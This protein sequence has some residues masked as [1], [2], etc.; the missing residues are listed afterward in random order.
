MA[1]LGFYTHIRQFIN[2]GK[3][4]L[5]LTSRA[6]INH[7]LTLIK[8]I[9]VD[10]SSLDLAE[11]GF[12][13][14]LLIDQIIG[15]AKKVSANAL[16][17]NPW[18]DGS[19]NYLSG[20]ADQSDLGEQKFLEH[21]IDRSHEQQILIFAWLVVGKDDF[22]SLDHPEW[23]AKTIAGQ[24]YYHNDEPGVDL[25][26]ASLANQDYLNYHLSV[27][28]EV[29]QLAIDGWV[30]SEPIIGWGD[31][32]D[33]NYIDFSEAV[34]N[35]FQEKTGFNPIELFQPDSPSFWEQQT[36]L[37]QKWV[38]FR[39]AV[40][41]NHIASTINTIRQSANKTIIITLFTEPDQ[42]GRLKSLTEIKDWLGTDLEALADLKPDF[43]ELQAL[44][45]DFEFPQPPEWTKGMISQFQSQ[46]GNRSIPILVSVQGYDPGGGRL[47]A[48][49]FAKAMQNAL[50]S[51]IV[52]VSFYAYHTMDE[53][54]WRV[55][56]KLWSQY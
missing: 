38:D 30:I 22:P 1:W 24:P 34:I 4:R 44:F 42:N 45:A 54:K 50:A 55:L 53:D 37:Y 2:F 56:E 13:Q 7:P 5:P 21:L 39:A 47:T 9:R 49:D 29:N 18:S 20:I 19:A 10:L 27:V 14:N 17:V 28:K 43:F 26:V 23:F 41:T 33:T 25:P 16:F 15:R 3:H 46:L 35:L 51:P 52:G 12:D 31:K 36:D 40:V 8:S 11:E 6:P 48:Q 32:Y